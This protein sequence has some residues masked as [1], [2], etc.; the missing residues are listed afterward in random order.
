MVLRKVSEMKVMRI[1]E[2]IIERLWWK[3]LLIFLRIRLSFMC[4][5][6]V[7]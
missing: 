6:L 1:I 5:V 3:F 7:C 4:V 2:I